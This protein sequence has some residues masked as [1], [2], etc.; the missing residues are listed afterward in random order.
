MTL[1]F[2]FY[3]HNFYLTDRTNQINKGKYSHV[4]ICIV[5]HASLKACHGPCLAEEKIYHA[6]SARPNPTS[7]AYLEGTNQNGTKHERAVPCHHLYEYQIRYEVI[8]AQ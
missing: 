1:S 3:S 2:Y 4:Y 8:G 7:L 6:V 5:L